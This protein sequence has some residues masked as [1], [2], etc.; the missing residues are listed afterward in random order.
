MKF[1]A[2]C[3]I[4]WGGAVEELGEVLNMNKKKFIQV[5]NFKKYLH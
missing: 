4:C 1:G 2:R 3:E 5:L